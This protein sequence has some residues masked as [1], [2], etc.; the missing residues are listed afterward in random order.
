M[1]KLILKFREP[2]TWIGSGLLAGVITAFVGPEYVRP[3]TDALTAA[4]AIFEIY[5]REH[6]PWR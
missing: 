6:Q 2:S 4:L 5:R 3:V 1:K